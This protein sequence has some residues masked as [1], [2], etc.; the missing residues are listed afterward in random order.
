MNELR[1]ITYVVLGSQRPDV[2]QAM[3]PFTRLV[4][5]SDDEARHLLTCH[6]PRLFRAFTRRSQAQG[7]ANQLRAIGLAATALPAED[8]LQYA[9]LPSKQ[10]NVGQGG[11]SA[12][13]RE[14]EAPTFIPFSDVA[15][16]VQGEVLEVVGKEKVMSPRPGEP[17]IRCSYA[18]QMIVDVHRKSVP[19]GVRFRKVD[20]HLNPIVAGEPLEGPTDLAR[21]VSLLRE[22]SPLALFDD[23]FDRSGDSVDWSQRMVEAGHAVAIQPGGVGEEDGPPTAPPLPPSPDPDPG[24]LRQEHAFNLYSILWRYQAII[25]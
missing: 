4:K 13:G 22:R 14:G 21:F 11:I 16:I 6:G 19:V 2:G 12:F 23:R 18:P 7:M 24:R 25:E 20:F 17:K 1:G 8:I 10:V 15:I 5:I 9:I 3:R